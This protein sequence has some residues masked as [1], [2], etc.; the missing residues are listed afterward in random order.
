MYI[1]ASCPE[2]I[3]P[4]RNCVCKKDH[5]HAIDSNSLPSCWTLDEAQRMSE[6]IRYTLESE[7]IGRNIVSVFPSF[8]PNIPI[9]RAQ[10]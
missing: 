10:P 3:W 1:I 9:A 8:D 6:G 5:S 2:L 7:C 4:F